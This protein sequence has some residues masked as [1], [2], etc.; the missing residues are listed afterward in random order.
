MR[1]KEASAYKMKIN[2]LFVTNRSKEA[3][4]VTLSVRSAWDLYF[5]VKQFPR[6]SEVIFTGITIPDM[7]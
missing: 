7:T 3:S 2:E 5:Q 1:E 4:L 6:G